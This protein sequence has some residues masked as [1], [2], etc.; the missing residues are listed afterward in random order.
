MRFGYIRV[1]SEEQN[2][3]RQFDALDS[4]KLDEI[5]TDKASGANL[6]RKDWMRLYAQLRV[7]DE[8]Y[9]KSIDR[10]SRSTMDF[11]SLWHD[12][13]E[14]G[15][16]LVVKDLGMTLEVGNQLTQFIVTVMA[17]AAQLER[18]QIRTRQREGYEAAKLRNGGEVKGRGES[19]RVAQAKAQLAELMHR[20]LTDSE[21]M[22]LIGVSRA[23]YYKLKKEVCQK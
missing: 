4:Y 3:D 16:K 5:F 20:D 21:R 17:A 6:D 10:L 19:K 2:Y 1:S 22:K 7:G 14:K 11:L 15:V 18:G 8:I 12:L 9:V 23:T 13:A